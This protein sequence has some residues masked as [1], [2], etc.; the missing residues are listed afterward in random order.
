MS[1][2]R[3]SAGQWRAWF[4]EFDASGL[5]VERFCKV[6]NKTANTFYLWRKKLG[7]GSVRSSRVKESSSAIESIGK[8]VQPR[9]VT[10]TPIV[11]NH[12][13]EVELELPNAVKVRVRNLQTD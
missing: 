7:L 1:R 13:V 2:K 11:D 10:A 9:F 6:K 8:T 5:T 4:D 12:N 3:F